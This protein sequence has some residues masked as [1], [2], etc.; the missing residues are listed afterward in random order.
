MVLL[1]MVIMVPLA[2]SDLFVAYLLWGWTAVVSIDSYLFGFAQT[3]R[4]NLI[5]ALLT[6][7]MLVLAGKQAKGKLQLD[8]TTVLL[9]LFCMQATASALFAFP[10]NPNNLELFERFV[11]A[12]LF[13]LL[14]P[15]VVT[16]RYRVHAMVI[17]ITAGLAFHGL[18][19]GLKF[20]ASGGRHIVTG[21]A[22]FGD[23]NHFAALLVMV[24]PLLIYLA[25]YSIG[26]IARY[27]S[28]FVALAVIG[29]VIGTHSRGGFVGLSVVGI[30]LIL[31]SRRR[32]LAIFFV[33]AGTALAFN[34]APESWTNRM[35]TI[36]QAEQDSSFMGRVEAWHVS[37]AIAVGN[38][39]LGG[40]FHAVQTPKVWSQYRFNGG[41]LAW[42]KDMPQSRYAPA[43][44]S[45]Y[46]E[47][48]G[49][50]G[51]SGLIIF[52]AILLNALKIGKEI[53]AQANAYGS[54]FLWATDLARALSLVIIAFLLTGFAVSIAYYEVIYIVVMMMSLLKRIVMDE[55][56]TSSFE[57]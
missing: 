36:D 18:V 16:E 5:F 47:V 21:L 55:I 2:L 53:A 7:T 32:L 50:L 38:P 1:G 49:D 41:L 6:L 33:A 20:F 22:K 44:H 23:N 12:M 43:A 28:I 52:M 40:G 15:L 54:K 39:L 8:S 35:E 56:Q 31:A 57:K 3:L 42:V 46:F 14:M 24:L 45:I 10:D 27:G 37:S 11:K 29:A 51:F 26:K 34:F 25:Q 17:M 13:V 30:L 19:D 48:L 9:A 4:F